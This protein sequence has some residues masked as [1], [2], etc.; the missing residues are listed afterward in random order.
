MFNFLV[1]PVPAPIVDFHAVFQSSVLLG[2]SQSHS[3]GTLAVTRRSW[4]V[5]GM[6]L[7]LY[8]QTAENETI[9]RSWRRKL[10]SRYPENK[11]NFRTDFHSMHLPRTE[12]GT[13]QMFQVW[14]MELTVFA[15]IGE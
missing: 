13:V 11:V 7:H 5:Q 1:K 10:H 4:L 6:E 15:D 2:S 8:T 3:V 14:K 12:N 9:R